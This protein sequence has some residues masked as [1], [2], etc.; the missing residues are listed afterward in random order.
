MLAER[1]LPD[2]DL[3]AWAVEPKLDGWRVRVT[4][5]D[6]RLVVRSRPGRDIT[7]SVPEV[8]AALATLPPMV[9]DG[10][11]IAGCGR[12]ED[13]YRLSGRL[14]ALIRP[15]LSPPVTFAA[16]DVLSLDGVD[17]TR[18]PYRER[19]Q[20]LEDLALDD[21]GATVV[22]SY[23]GTD[24]VPLLAACEEQGLEGVVLKRL[25][26]AYRPGR[27]SPDWRKVKCPSWVDHA[28]RRKPPRPA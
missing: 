10:E 12:L 21:E 27:R 22:P 6:G 26:S 17:L 3:D 13:F 24:A 1:G 7:G 20:L 25:T 4:V 9:L 14:S 15:D 11:L 19:R 16:F 2:G 8:V 5:A 18:L 28:E 23:P